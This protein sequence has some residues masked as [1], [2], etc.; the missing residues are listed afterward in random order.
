MSLP[1]LFYGSYRPGSGTGAS[2]IFPLLGV[3][4]CHWRFVASEIDPVSITS[5]QRNVNANNLQDRICIV[6]SNAEQI[7]IGVLPEDQRL[8]VSFCTA[9]TCPDFSF[10]QF[11]ILCVQSS[12]LF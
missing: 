12:I 1:I 10:K 9:L 8:I 7:L 5:A 3:R 2:C 6:K 4:A 11:R